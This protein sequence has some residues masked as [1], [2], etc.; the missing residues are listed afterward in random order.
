[1]NEKDSH[2]T[3]NCSEQFDTSAALIAEAGKITEFSNGKSSL[4]IGSP[5]GERLDSF[6][7]EEN[8]YPELSDSEQS[9]Y[10]SWLG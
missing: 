2:S 8:S 10:D 9:E 3:V 6:A 4:T 7:E 1:M 5:V